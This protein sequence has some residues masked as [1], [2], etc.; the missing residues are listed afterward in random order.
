MLQQ[1]NILRHLWKGKG[2]LYIR[3]P[4]SPAQNLTPLSSVSTHSYISNDEEDRVSTII[5]GT[6][7]LALALDRP[8][9]SAFAFG[10]ANNGGSTRNRPLH[11]DT[12]TLHA[13]VN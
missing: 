8:C 9:L 1:G 3:R 7:V 5:Y 13:Y 12:A 11:C 2:F 6:Y 10:L 4:S